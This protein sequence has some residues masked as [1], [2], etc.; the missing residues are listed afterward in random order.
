MYYWNKLIGKTES[1]FVATLQSSDKEESASDFVTTI[2][3]LF[4]FPNFVN[5]PKIYN[6]WEELKNPSSS[7]FINFDD[8][9]FYK[10]WNG[11]AI[12]NF[13]WKTF[14]RKYYLAIWAIY[15]IFICSFITVVALS[16]K[17]SWD[18]QIFFLNTA[19][20]L[21]FWHLFFEIRQFYYS[22]QQ[23]FSS[24]WNY[25][26][27]PAI[28]STIITSVYWLMNGTVSI[29]AITFSTL[30]LELQF[31]LF[32]RFIPF[33]ESYLALIMNTIDKVLSF[34]IIFG[35]IIFAFAHALFLLLQST[36][37]ISQSSNGI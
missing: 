19:I 11:E 26:D 14:G 36:S 32:F 35:L 13:K 22:P 27:L 10:T 15:T 2:I 34:L 8:L 30:L 29:W 20:I 6:T 21:G 17:I 37:E 23:Y 5:Y 18:Y 7:C 3:F 12:I 1:D 31:I 9:S 28:I 4:P 16:N 24:A 25:I 33:F